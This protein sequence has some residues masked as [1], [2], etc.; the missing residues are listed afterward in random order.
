LFSILVIDDDPAHSRLV[1][2]ILRAEATTLVSA[3]DGKSGIE[4]VATAA[5]DVVL[6][7]MELPDMKGFAVLASITASAPE[8]PVIMVTG[9][10]GL[11]SAIRATRLGAFDYLTKP[12]QP[13]ELINAVRR[14]R[15]TCT[16]RREVADLRRKAGGGNDL[17]AQMGSSAIIR[18]VIEQVSTVSAS[19]FTV[20]ILGETGTGKEL[21]AQAIHRGSDR[22]TGPFVALDCGAIPEALLESE[23]FGHQKGAFTGAD[24]SKAGRFQLAEG[25]TLFLDEIGNLPMSLQSKLLRVLESKELMS[26]GAVRSTAMDVR[27]IAATNDDLQAR[28]GAG[29]FRADLY[30]RLAQYTITLPPLRERPT[31][32]A[33]LA[34]RFLEESSVELRRPV[35]SIDADAIELL[36]AQ[37]W[38]GNVRELRNVVRQAVLR[39][40]GLVIQKEHLRALFGKAGKAGKIREAAPAPLTNASLKDVAL[41]AAA[42]A[43]KRAICETLRATHGNKSEAARALRTDYKTLHVKIKKLGIRARDFME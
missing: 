13:D 22:R 40:T 23:L 24:R 33:S 1:A 37:A 4:S 28:V 21:V 34:T 2:R 18:E 19:L 9:D 25:G 17:Y 7:D 35:R 3:P 42:A 32:I 41:E 31:D 11:K 20:L 43:E 39:S 26:V 16:L 12:I 10:S 5:P 36:E 30:F 14:A 27:F 15:E 29:V 8:L 6:L 38:P